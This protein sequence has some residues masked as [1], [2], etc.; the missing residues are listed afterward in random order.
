MTGNKPEDPMDQTPV[1]GTPEI[2]AR[3]EK[4]DKVSAETPKVAAAPPE[5]PA[6][7]EPAPRLSGLRL[8]DTF[9]GVDVV[10]RK[11][12]ADIGNGRSFDM[13][14]RGP[15]PD[16]LYA[17]IRRE[18]DDLVIERAEGN[19]FMSV[20]GTQSE[21]HKLL[22]GV[23]LKLD[24]HVIEVEEAPLLVRKAESSEVPKGKQ[25]KTLIVLLVVLLLM[26]ALGVLLLSVDSTNSR[27]EV[28][29][30]PESVTRGSVSD[31]AASPESPAPE[32]STNSNSQPEADQPEPEKAE[33]GDGPGE[34]ESVSSVPDAETP[35]VTK[36]EA[37]T[38]QEKSAVQS[39]A[40]GPAGDGPEPAREA[41]FSRY[42]EAGVN[43]E[44]PGQEPP[45]SI[46]RAGP[47]SS[48]DSVTEAES[49]DEVRSEPDADD[50]SGAGKA[51][52]GADQKT[53]AANNKTEDGMAVA[54][55]DDTG[56]E[57]S[58]TRVAAESSPA[59]TRTTTETV[60][61]QKAGA[62]VTGKQEQENSESSVSPELLQ[63]YLNGEL[64][65]PADKDWP[66]VMRAAVG[67]AADGLA[68]EEISEMRQSWQTLSHAEKF[69]KVYERPSRPRAELRKRFAEALQ[70]RAEQRQSLGAMAGAYRSY[71]E[72]LR[73]GVRTD[74]AVEFVARQDEEAAELYRF[75]YR[76]RYTDP[77]TTRVY[78]Q[79]V[80]RHVSAA[81]DWYSKAANG[82]HELASLGVN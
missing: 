27:V 18:D 20:Q 75:G 64:A 15:G 59:E 37:E 69:M 5:S 12:P 8:R 50:I 55:A 65:L 42:A 34:N 21:K 54:G 2:E 32:S 51:P 81:S 76:L 58:E 44:S 28:V 73:L 72:L 9:S 13:P 24:E 39:P 3:S 1:M 41:G 26:M 48:A 23:T 17:T 66:A 82:L 80:S 43:S 7:A 67:A 35:Q 61:E 25:R 56:T 71:A 22:P 63:A 45:G 6:L 62:R 10:F 29:P 53:A 14:L 47:E 78:W 57:T 16:G 79:E 52:A 31:A 46:Q 60:T 11:F 19:I 30:M 33:S 77:H 49:P 4:S 74:T 38:P 70:D 40:D 68:T 36:E